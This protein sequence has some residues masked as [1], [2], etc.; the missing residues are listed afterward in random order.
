[1][2][3]TFILALDQGTTSS[4]SLLIDHQGQVRAQ[5][6]L[7]FEQLYPE[8]GWVEHRP[9][10][11]W[12]SQWNTIQRVIGSAGIAPHQIAGIGIANQRETTLIWDRN[13]GQPVYNAIVWQDR[14]TAEYCDR[15]KQ[16]P[17]TVED[18]QSRT[19]L[20][21]DA[22]FSASKIRWILDHVDGVRAR[23]E[24]GELAFGTVETWLVWNL[25]QGKS[26]ITD[27]SNA[28]RTML[29]NI[30]TLQWD[31]DLCAL[32]DIPLAILPEVVEN[33]G[34]LALATVFPQPI[35]IAGLAGDQQA[36]LFGQQCTQPGMVK[37]TY[38]TGCFML[39]NTGTKAV[40]SN[41]A[42]LTT[43]AWN[44]GGITTYALEGSVFIGGAAV[45]WFR[46]QLG[47]ISQASDIEALAGSVETSE[48]VCIVPAFAGLGAPHWNPHARG[49]IFGMTRGTGKA[50]LARA[51]LESI[52][53]QSMELLH[54]MQ[55]DSHV[56]MVEMRVDGGAAQNALLMQIQSNVMNLP[57]V[58]PTHV[59]STALG[60]AFFAGIGSGFWKSPDDVA[61]CW[62]ADQTFHPDSQASATSHLIQNWHRAIRAAAIWAGAPA[63]ATS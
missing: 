12:E 49:T 53:L 14:R 31:A 28:S 9:E 4:R 3:S 6:Q 19:G 27:A 35:T 26:H 59:E 23:A 13:T 58:R 16:H 36:A 11:L 63:E 29:L 62:Q 47:V 32:F 39:M 37:N 56:H 57:V 7:E 61:G 38:G 24:R 55:H 22:Y 41:H 48:G 54:A 18:I 34:S 1:M 45:Q 5:S 40:K 44:T 43:I 52:A 30:H 33:C 51:V 8:P 60:A 2:E 50:H 46:D 20:V 25:T 42:L 10:D 15:L 17:K 21:I